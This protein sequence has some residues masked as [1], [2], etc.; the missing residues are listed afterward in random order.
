MVLRDESLSIASTMFG[1]L[2]NKDRNF[3]SCSALETLDMMNGLYPAVEARVIDQRIDNVSAKI[4]NIV[5]V[6]W[7]S[8]KDGYGSRRSWVPR[9]FL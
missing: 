5:Y 9:V 4:R 1:L 8:E 6:R 2:L 7:S 3:W